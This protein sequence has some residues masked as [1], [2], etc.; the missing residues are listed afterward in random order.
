MT[1]SNCSI[2][3]GSLLPCGHSYINKMKGVKEIACQESEAKASFYFKNV[4]F[5]L[6]MIHNNLIKPEEI[7]INLFIYLYFVD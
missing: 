2:F 7:L 4:V 1:L 5:K 6:E 3:I